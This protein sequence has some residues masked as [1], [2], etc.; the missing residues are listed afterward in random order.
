MSRAHGTPANTAYTLTLTRDGQTIATLQNVSYSTAQQAYPAMLADHV[1]TS[2]YDD[3]LV[4]RDA[5]E[6]WEDLDSTDN[7]TY[8]GV[9]AVL[10]AAN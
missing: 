6:Y 10:Q 7:V 3:A 5:R 9:T 1:A 8:R 4:R 2:T